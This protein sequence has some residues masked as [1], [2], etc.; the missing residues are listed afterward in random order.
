MS[1]IDRYFAG[2]KAAISGAGDGIGRALALRLNAAGCDVWLCDLNEAKL[3]ET[4]GLLDHDRAK[5]ITR[6]V[7]CGNRDELFAWAGAVAKDTPAIDALFNNAGVGYGARF[8]DSTEDNFKWLIDI[9]FWGV[10]HATRA[11]LPLLNQSERAHLVNISSIF[12]MVGIPTQ[13]AYNAAKFAVRGFS[14]ALQAEYM[15]SMLF[16]SSVHPGGVQTN[17]ARSA[18]TDGE[19]NLVMA[20]ADERDQQFRRLAKT[21]PKRAADIILRGTAR[22]KRRI[23]VGWDAWLILQLTKILPTR[24][25]WITARVADD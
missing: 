15:D 21:T 18:R 19:G 20:D 13:S 25:H 7:D 8:E 24:Y 16:V 9:N 4:E 2:K 14:E 5:V 10:V 3:S 23:M 12:G 1:R 11:F 6:I 22:G 17:I